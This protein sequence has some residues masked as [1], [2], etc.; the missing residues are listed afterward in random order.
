MDVDLPAGNYAYICF[1]PDPATGKP[2]AQLGMVG[3][4]T[5]K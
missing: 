4:L 5:V 1:V 3:A 2:H